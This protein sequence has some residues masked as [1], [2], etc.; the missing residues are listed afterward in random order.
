MSSITFQSNSFGRDPME[1]AAASQARERRQPKEPRREVTNCQI[2][3]FPRRWESQEWS[4]ARQRAEQ[5]FTGMADER[6]APS[7]ARR[8]AESLFAGE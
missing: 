4:P 8:A 2:T 1:L 3:E 6:T 5:L 7:A